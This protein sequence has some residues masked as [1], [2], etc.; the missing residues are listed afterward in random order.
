VRV[1][2][3]FFAALREVVGRD[4]MEREVPQ[5]TTVGRLLDDLVSEYPRLSPFANVI[6][7][8]V[9]QEFT[10]RQQRVQSED[11]VAFL[12]PVSGG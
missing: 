7:V 1:R 9:N 10:G 12:P 4:A 2:V 8:A 5:G 6:Q 3:R 11:E